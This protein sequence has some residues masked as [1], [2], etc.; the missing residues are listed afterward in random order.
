MNRPA[1]HAASLSFL[2]PGSGELVTFEA[3]LPPDMRELLR[4][5][6]QAG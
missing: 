4:K 2:H 6:R 5:L 1:L 3:P